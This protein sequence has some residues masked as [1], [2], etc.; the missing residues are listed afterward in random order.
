MPFWIFS[1]SFL[2]FGHL[3]GAIWVQFGCL[4]GAVRVPFGCRSG[5]FALVSGDFRV[6]AVVPESTVAMGTV[7]FFGR[8]PFGDLKF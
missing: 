3:S 1:G 7:D 6:C 2:F 5:V 8:V 4:S